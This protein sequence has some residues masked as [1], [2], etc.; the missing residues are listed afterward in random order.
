MGLLPVEIAQPG[1]PQLGQDVLASY[2]SLR[3]SSLPLPQPMVFIGVGFSGGPG[4]CSTHSCHTPWLLALK[5]QD[6]DFFVL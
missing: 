6:G 5:G 1:G 2:L 4:P 3:P